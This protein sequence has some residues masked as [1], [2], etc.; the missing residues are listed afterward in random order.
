VLRIRAVDLM[1]AGT[2]VLWA[3][4]VTVARYILT[5]GFEPLAYAGLR[6]SAA[7]G[8]FAGVTIVRERSIRLRGRN[9]VLVGAAAT[10][11][12][13][14]NQLGFVYALR[15]TTASTVAL[16]SGAIPIAA[17][18]LAV[19]IGME[20][21]TRRF[22]VATLV[23]FAGVALVAVG[24]GGGVSGSLGGNLLALTTAVT[25]GAYSVAIASLTGAWSP[26]RISTVVLSSMSVLIV[27]TG[28]PQLLSQDY[29]AISAWVWFLFAVAVLGPLVLTN[30]LWFTALERVGPSHATLFANLQPFVGVL[31]A[32]LLLSERLSLLELAGGAA[33]A[34]GV[35]L[36]WRQAPAP[37]PAE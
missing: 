34:L 10:A 23:S 17:A 3:L 26:F 30:V 6:Y 1:L 28:L 27:L 24:S 19:A 16:I 4:N 22:A 35:A 2:V 21:L 9:A 29:A 32:V 31:F 25:W 15:L 20:R 18:A 8:I 36:V 13:Y 37:V 14:L 33:I 12:L 5:H 11:L 7:A